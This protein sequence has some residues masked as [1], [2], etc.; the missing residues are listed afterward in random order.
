MAGLDESPE[1][2]RLRMY[3]ASNEQSP[4]PTGVRLLAVAALAL[5]VVAVLTPSWDWGAGLESRITHNSFAAF[6]E[7]EDGQ[8]FNTNY[9]AEHGPGLTVGFELHLAEPLRAMLLLVTTAGDARA[10]FPTDP[11]EAVAFDPG[12]HALP[13]RLSM[14]DR[15]V[16]AFAVAIFD[17]RP[18]DL[19]VIEA[20]LADLA[21]PL[22]YE[23]MRDSGAFPGSVYAV[24]L[25][26]LD[27]T[28]RSR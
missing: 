13:V 7:N 16:E 14:S 19:A 15:A 1:H 28:G 25:P 23:A 4:A 8:R 17:S 2:A 3:M 27:D 10:L 21:R 6:F 22:T 11:P 12:R 5:I 24:H 18:F 9:R 20:A 26:A